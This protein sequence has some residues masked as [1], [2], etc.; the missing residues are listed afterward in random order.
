M[1]N[2]F[3][4]ETKLAFT[5]E[6][7]P[8]NSIFSI[9][10]NN[11]LYRISISIL[12]KCFPRHKCAPYPNAKCLFGDLSTLNLKG[13]SKTSSSLFPDGY[14]NNIESPFLISFSPIRQSSV[15]VLKKFFYFAFFS[16]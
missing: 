14:T 4:P 3:K 1:G 8:F 2:D 6:G 7:S 12:A 10:L 9:L 15:A 5:Q 13:S 11:S 16:K